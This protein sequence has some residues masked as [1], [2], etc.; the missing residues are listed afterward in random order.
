MSTSFEIVPY[1][2]NF[3]PDLLDIWH[4]GVKKTHTFLSEQDFIFYKH[5]VDKEALPNIE[6]WIALNM[7][8]HPLGFVGVNGKHIEM[9]FVDP[10]IHR[11]GVGT[12]LLNFVIRTKGCITV[13]VNEQNSQARAFYKRYG[14]IEKGRAETDDRGKPYP[15]IQLELADCAEKQRSLWKYYNE[16]AVRLSRCS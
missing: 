11:Q 15:L 4:R 12:A 3:H 5:I 2:R 9:L 13:D 1:T 7:Q 14:F 10:D 8:M 16:W 6:V